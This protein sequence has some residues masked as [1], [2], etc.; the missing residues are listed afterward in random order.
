MF[1]SD[2]KLIISLYPDPDFYIP[3]RLSHIREQLQDQ[4][5]VTPAVTPVTPKTIEDTVQQDKIYRPK[6]LIRYSPRFIAVNS[7]CPQEPCDITSQLIF[8]AN[9]KAVSRGGLRSLPITEAIRKCYKFYN[10]L[11]RA[12]K[13]FYR[14]QRRN[15]NK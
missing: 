5:S 4:P 2:K 13:K 7:N 6:K 12:H 8:L 11:Q 3:T 14:K 9:N 10:Y 1:P 15:L